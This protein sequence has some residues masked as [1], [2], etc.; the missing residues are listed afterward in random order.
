MA[1]RALSRMSHPTLRTILH[2]TIVIS[3]SRPLPV[4]PRRAKPG[5]VRRELLI[6]PLFTVVNAHSNLGF[7]EWDE[8]QRLWFVGTGP[9]AMPQM[10]AK[11]VDRELP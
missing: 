5:T 8:S 11:G 7:A 2:R 4:S 6:H 3:T 9:M 1:S 10:T